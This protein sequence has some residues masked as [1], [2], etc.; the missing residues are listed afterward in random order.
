VNRF[1]YWSI[2]G[3]SLLLSVMLIAA[4]VLAVFGVVPFRSAQPVLAAG[5]D[6]GTPAAGGGAMTTDGGPPVAALHRDDA[7]AWNA[8]WQARPQAA[9]AGPERAARNDRLA[10]EASAPAAFSRADREVAHHAEP[11][12]AAAAAGERRG[13]RSTPDA[14]ISPAAP[15]P[16]APPEWSAGDQPSPGVP[17]IVAGLW[18]EAQP[19]TQPQPAPDEPADGPGTGEPGDGDEDE[20]G[21]PDGGD[22]DGGLPDQDSPRG[23]LRL[24]LVPGHDEVAPGELVS[25]RVVLSEADRISSVPFHVR[26]N[27]EVLEYVGAKSGPAITDSP[28]QPILLAAVNPARPDDLAVGLALVRSSGRFSGSGTVVVLDF[29]A[30]RAGQSD[31]LLEKASVRDSNSRPLTVQ[32]ENSALSV[33]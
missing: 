25:V 11:A 15:P 23:P 8:V 7:G 2:Y 10:D 19:D 9:G 16:A 14:S 3:G 33:R 22:G 20:G 18:P 5:Y 27:S 21:E 26:F 28:V 17:L 1:L 29:R 12:A 13:D 31:L 30:L 24:S 4:A 32:I 6:R